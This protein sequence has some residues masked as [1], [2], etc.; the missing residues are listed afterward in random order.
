MSAKRPPARERSTYICC[1]R[2]ITVA[3]AA[4]TLP[5][6]RTCGGTMKLIER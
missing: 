5:R 6:C 4:A 3:A 1:G 2:T